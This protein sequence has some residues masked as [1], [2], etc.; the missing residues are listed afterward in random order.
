MRGVFLTTSEGNDPAKPNCWMYPLSAG[1]WRIFRFGNTGKISEAETWEESPGGWKT[2][3]INITPSFYQVGKAFGAV[4]LPSTTANGLVFANLDKAKAAVAAYGS[5]LGLPRW[6]E[7]SKRPRPVTLKLRKGGGLLAEFKY[8]NEIDEEDGRDIEATEA[9]WTKARGPVWAKVIDVDTAPRRMNY[10]SLADNAVRQVSLNGE[11]HGLYVHT[12]DGKWDRQSSDRIKDNLT[13]RGIEGGLQ[14]DL[15]GWISNNPFYL[16]ARPFAGEYPGN[17]EWNLQ[18]SQLLYAPA[19]ADGPT[20]HW[21]MILDHIGRGLDDAVE[22]DP[23]CQEYNVVTGADYLRLWIANL[24]RLP[25]RRLPMLAMYSPEQGTGKSTLHEATAVL[26]DET[27]FEYGDAALKNGPG[28]NGE[29]YGRALC[30]VEETNLANYKEA[31]I[32]IKSWVTSPRMQITFKGKTS[33]TTDNYTHWILST[34]NRRSI[35]IE[36]GD[37]RIVLWEVTPFEGEE[38]DK[39]KLLA[40][41]RKEAPFFMRQLWN[42]DVSGVAG[43]HTLPVLM[44]KEKA[45]A[46]K[47]VAEERPFPDLEGDAHKAAE[48]IFNMDKPWGPGSASALCEELGDWDGESKKSLKS[49]ANTLGRYLK[50]IQPFLENKGVIL[51]IGRG[52]Q[53]YSVWEE[54]QANQKKTADKP[55]A[56]AVQAGEPKALV[57]MV[58]QPSY[59]TIPTQ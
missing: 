22:S 43:R 36:P 31:Y 20:T 18:G 7:E 16:V 27:G 10:A 17:R 24:I 39:D 54:S 23:W 4:R 35:P 41:L 50:K 56:M 52:K 38:I 29:L 37:T 12:N 19:S 59:P 33:F 9:G 30:A 55:P 13:H 49:R 2:C 15:L 21:D 58:D 14:K 1:A 28:F 57:E 3:T 8:K 6:A 34:Q 45:K 5:T 47:A 32:R 48:A 42:L 46:M 11:Q 40:I 44:T 51:E 26:F 25:A 53:P